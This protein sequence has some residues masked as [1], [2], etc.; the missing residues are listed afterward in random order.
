MPTLRTSR[1]KLRFAPLT[2]E[3]WEDLEELFGKSGAYAGCWCMWWRVTRSRFDRE[4]GSGNRRAFRKIVQS[5]EVPGILAYA[6]G[7]PVGWC[8]V[9][10]RETFSSLNRSPVLKKLDDEPVWSIVCLFVTRAY[11][12]KGI[13]VELIRAAVR[14]VRERGGRLIE[15]YPT[16]PRGKRLQPVSSFMGTPSVFAKAGFR[17]CARP[18]EAK[19]IMRCPANGI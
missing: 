4:H 19:V 10:P 5:G 7:K 2:P 1:S 11:R 16:D 9:A 18:S 17:E 15:A 8:S 6:S 12:G 13:T 14:Y 3:R